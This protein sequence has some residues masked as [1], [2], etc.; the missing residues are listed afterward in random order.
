ML[1]AY[2][3]IRR[4]EEQKRLPKEK[5]LKYLQVISWAVIAGAVFTLGLGFDDFRILGQRTT[6]FIFPYFFNLFSIAA[7]IFQVFVGLALGKAKIWARPALFSLLGLRLLF[8][9]FD[10]FELA[11]A[12]ILLVC[13]IFVLLSGF[14]GQLFE[15]Q[16][17]L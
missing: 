6:S 14:C 12:L 1:S 8:A 2:A 5:A 13:S 11:G 3:I 7:S 16:S 10:Y 15:K 4:M 17:A 9:L